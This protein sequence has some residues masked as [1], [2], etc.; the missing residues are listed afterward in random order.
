MQHDNLRV[1]TSHAP[2]H[3]FEVIQRVVGAHGH[4]DIPGRHANA[5][6]REFGFRR[7]IELIEFHMGGAGLSLADAVLGD[8]KNREKQRRKR[9]SSNRRIGLGKEVDD[10]NCE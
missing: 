6:R 9:E 8:F 7:Q 10:R 5:C 4:Q 2:Q 1:M 3:G